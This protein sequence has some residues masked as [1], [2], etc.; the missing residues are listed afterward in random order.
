MQ[1]LDKPLDKPIGLLGGTFD[2]IHF[3][4]LR[5]GLELCND[6][7]LANVHIIPCYQPVH[8]HAPAATPAQRLDMVKVAVSHEPTLYA[9]DREIR[10]QGP[11]YMVDTV[12]ELRAEKPN[13]PLCLLIGVDAFLNFQ[14]WQ[15]WQTILD[16]THIILSHRP[17]YLMPLSG[18]I[19]D[20]IKE[21]LQT[22]TGFIHE[23][24]AGGILLHPITALEISA[25]AIRK[26]IA[27]GRN[28]RYLLPDEVLNYIQQQGTYRI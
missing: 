26:Q 24:L 7:D 13:T 3:G 6:L 14:S 2:P 10:R 21:R 18:Q 12:L 25:S 20:L 5:M 23:H 1:Q 8:R 9:D 4:H 17:N 27:L 11:S 16:H 22:D 15:R 19:A 28:P